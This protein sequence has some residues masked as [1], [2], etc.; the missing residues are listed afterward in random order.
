MLEFN[1][2]TM[3]F[4]LIVFIILMVLVA[5][6]GMRP[7]LEMMRKRQDHITGEISAAEENRKEAERVLEEQKAELAKTREEA[8]DIV[9]RAKKRSENEA[10]DILKDAKARADR[11]VEEAREEIQNE[12]NKAISR[13]RDEVAEL[14]VMLASRVL[15]REVDGKEHKEEISQFM[16]QVGERL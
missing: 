8:R 15:E 12:Q 9:E 7:V 1:L 13:L 2:G 14:S 4:Q 5:K 16:K 3:L 10:A 11:L 6:F